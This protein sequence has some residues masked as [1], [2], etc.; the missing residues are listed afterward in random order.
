MFVLTKNGELVMVGEQ[1]ECLHYIMRAEGED[2]TC[3]LAFAL[4]YNITKQQETTMPHFEEAKQAA[5]EMKSRNGVKLSRAYV[6]GDPA[7]DD[8]KLIVEGVGEITI[9]A[10]LPKELIEQIEDYYYD[11]FTKRMSERAA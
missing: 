1:V 11:L 6:T 10:T 2:T 8:G 3:S 5:K 9:K 7:F 4:G